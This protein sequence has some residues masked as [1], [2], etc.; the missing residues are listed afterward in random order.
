MRL[1]F[2]V[3]PALARY[4]VEKGSIAVSGVSLTVNEAAGEGF[5]VNVIPETLRATTLSDLRPGSGVNIVV[6]II[7]KYVERLLAG[8]GGAGTLDMEF[9]RRHGFAD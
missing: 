8:R 5:S 3:P 2:R 7:G 9:L 1:S 6:D 4:I